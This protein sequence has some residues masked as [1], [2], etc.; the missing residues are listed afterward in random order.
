MQKT[1]RLLWPVLLCVMVNEA[2]AL[3]LSPKAVP[4][5]DTKIN[6]T[7]ATVQKG[8]FEQEC[9]DIFTPKQTNCVCVANIT[10]PVISGLSDENAQ[11]DLNNQFFTFA[12]DGSLCEGAP[13]KGHSPL[14][15]STGINQSK[16]Q[17]NYRVDINNAHFLVISQTADAFFV[18]AAHGMHSEESYIINTQTGQRLSPQAIFGEHLDEVNA[19]IYHYLK[20]NKSLVLFDEIVE[21]QKNRFLTAQMC[22]GCS[23]FVTSAGIKATF[24]E[25]SIGPYGAGQIDVL[26]PPKFVVFKPLREW[27]MTHSK[28]LAKT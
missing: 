14:K 20:N 7:T 1:K 28:P 6:I 8:R 11:R 22:N 12:H 16:T 2:F 5:P 17:A 4:P 10:R 3:P 19:H 26:I 15:L 23:L 9:S 25:Y 27:L 21:E 24:G 13:K 18:G